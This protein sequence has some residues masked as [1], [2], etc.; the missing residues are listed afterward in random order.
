MKRFNSRKYFLLIIIFLTVITNTLK[1]DSGASAAFAPLQ[2]APA[3]P[4]I[5]RLDSRDLMFRQYQADVQAAR[6]HLFSP[7]RSVEEAADFLTIFSYLVLEGDELIRIAAR[8][9]IPI[10]AIV[11]LNRLSH[12]E[13]LEAGML[14]LLPSMPGIFIPEIPGSDLE[15]L[16]NSTRSDDNPGIFLTVPRNG[17]AERFMFIPG[18]DFTS[19]ERIF[20]LNRGFRFPLRDFRVTSPFGPRINPVTGRAGMHRGIDLAAPHG[21]EVFAVRAGVVT[22]IGYGSYLG[23]YIVIEHDNN[24]VSLYGHLSSVNTSLNQRVN[25]GAFIGRVGSTGQS[26]G[27]HLHFELIQNGRHQDPARLFGIR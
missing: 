2:E 4:L 27:P 24:W 5:P 19:T 8:T 13:D 7:R 21:S 9:N 10:A 3:L 15:R 11:S 12:T 26:T 14:L 16:I 6:R 20:F 17:A 22:R 18:D 25:S 23:N 1:A